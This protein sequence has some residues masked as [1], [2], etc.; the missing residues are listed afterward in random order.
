MSE[1]RYAYQGLDPVLH[2]PARLS[3]STALYAHPDGLTFVELRDL[4]E[5]SD[6]NLSRHLR[7]LES[8][9]VVDTTKTFVERMPQT[10]ARLS[11]EGRRRFESYLEQ[12]RTIV[13][14]DI[15][16]SARALDSAREHGANAVREQPGLSGVGLARRT[17]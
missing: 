9:G 3:I 4:C 2:A 13:E 5:L 17:P 12:L 16:G 11:E 6:G 15:R 10:T 1:G 7:K 8:E 14:E